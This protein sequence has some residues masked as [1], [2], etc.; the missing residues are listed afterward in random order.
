MHKGQAPIRV[1][2]ISNVETE[3]YYLSN[4][5]AFTSPRDI[6]YYA[7]TLGSRGGFVTEME[8]NGYPAYA[9]DCMSRRRYPRAVTRIREIVTR[10]AIDI[11]HTHLFEPTLVG[12]LVARR[13]A[14]RIIVTRHHSDA[15]HTIANP[16]KRAAYLRAEHWVNRSAD[17]IIAPSRM[18]QEVLLEREGVLP[19]KVSLI[20]YGQT[21]SR[22]SAVTDERVARVEHELGMRNNLALVCVSRLFKQKGHRYLFEAFSRLTRDGFDAT[23]YLVGRGPDLELLRAQARQF[24]IA[25]RV[26]FLGWRDDALAIIAAAEI[27]VHPS[28][29]EALPSAVIE[30]LMLARPLVVTDVSGVRDMVGDNDHGIIV[31][32]ADAE[33]LYH[34]LNQ[35]LSDLPAARR[36]AEKGRRFV[37]EYMDASRVARE[38][39]A[40]YYK[41]TNRTP[42]FAT[43]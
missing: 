11:V 42:S 1:L 27:V 36:R 40:C 18:V 2:H 32:P 7:L 17:H 19:A 24:Q 22:F 12:V 4:L 37:L 26:K 3:N 5:F 35:T 6:K 14:A 25:E 21:T 15:V 41:V 16:V 29:H 39:V 9:L 34:G 28:L 8:R 38:Y 43:V 20:P 30:A 31:P 23:L 13:C 33:A 10:E